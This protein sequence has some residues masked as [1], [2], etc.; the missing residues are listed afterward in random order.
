[1][2]SVHPQDLRSAQLTVST[3][4][5]SVSLNFFMEATAANGALHPLRRSAKD[6]AA[7]Y[8]TYC[9]CPMIVC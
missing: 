2:L 6:C 4:E 3:Q 1:M 8:T 5:T 7:Q 9:R